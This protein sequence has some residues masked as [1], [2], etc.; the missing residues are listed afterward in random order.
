MRLASST[1]STSPSSVVSASRSSQTSS[2]ASFRWSSRSSCRSVRSRRVSACSP[3][4][5]EA[6]L[7]RS[8]L[9]FAE[10]KQRLSEP[11]QSFTTA[12]TSAQDASSPFARGM[13]GHCENIST[14]SRSAR[15]TTCQ[16]WWSHRA[17]G[18]GSAGLLSSA[19]ADALFSP[20]ALDFRSA[21]R[22]WTKGWSFQD[23]GM[24]VKMYSDRIAASKARIPWIL[25]NC[26]LPKMVGSLA[27]AD[28]E[29]YRYSV[30]RSSICSRV[31]STG[32]LPPASPKQT[33]L[34]SCSGSRGT[35]R[36]SRQS[37]VVTASGSPPS[38]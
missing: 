6:S 28:T 2:F 16:N 15:F 19:P 24:Q 20:A 4:F 36:S 11:A 35:P 13:S 31:A 5:S 9:C 10:S 30:G 34:P 14:C 3:A 29:T 25:R 7:R 22:H 17:V 38:C 27:T 37:A 32:C 18:A 21:G 23:A 8:R 1:G 33:T 12:D 26:E